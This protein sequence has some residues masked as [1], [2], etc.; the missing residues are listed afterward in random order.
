MSKIRVLLIDDHPIVRSGMRIL[1]EQAADIT[2]VGEAEH[3]GEAVE[4]VAALQP[5]VVLL[6]MEMPGK[7]GIEVARE[8]QESG[9]PARVLALSAYDDEQYILKLLENGAAGYLTKEEA[10]STLVEAVRGVAYGETGW[11]THRVAGRI[12]RSEG[13]EATGDRAFSER[14]RQALYMV[15]KNWSHKKIASG[16]GMSD[17]QV[18]ELLDGL[19]RKI[20]VATDDEAAHWAQGHTPL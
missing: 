10:L 1:L 3:G 13:Q 15:A 16:L 14:E 8:L 12:A 19:Y 4:I 2:V 9:L 7:S 18:E 5:D 17:A 20:G 11:V 6:D